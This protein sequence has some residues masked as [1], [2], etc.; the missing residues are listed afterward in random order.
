MAPG[1][2]DA[3]HRHPGAEHA[4]VVFEGR[5]LVTVDETTETLEPLTG[6]RVEPGLDAP[7]R[8]HRPAAAALLRLLV[9]RHGSAG[10]S[11]AGRG[12]A[13]DPG[14]LGLR[15]PPARLDDLDL[16]RLGIGGDER[17]QRA[18]PPPRSPRAA[19]ALT[20]VTSSMVIVATPLLPA[21]APG[22]RDEAIDQD[23]ALAR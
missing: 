9:A 18:S 4:I 11:R 10:G 8:E 19:P 1:A 2:A 22:A 14:R 15:R 21:D 5:G 23:A 6:I 3:W 20:G 17:E 13:A 12:A 16:T 7:R